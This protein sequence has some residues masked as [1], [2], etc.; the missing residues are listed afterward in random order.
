MKLCDNKIATFDKKKSC[1]F[2]KET[3][4]FHLLYEESL[5]FN[6]SYN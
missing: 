2:M 3:I 5:S 4:F 6:F 1:H